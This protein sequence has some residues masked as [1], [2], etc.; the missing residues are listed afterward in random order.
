MHGASFLNR[1]HRKPFPAATPSWQLAPRPRIKHEKWTAGSALETWTVAAA[2]GVRFARVRWENNFLLIFETAPFFCKHPVYTDF[3][4]SYN[5]MWLPQAPLKQ[6]HLGTWR[7]VTTD[8]KAHIN[9][10]RF[11]NG[12]IRHAFYLINKHIKLCKEWY[13]PSTRDADGNK[14]PAARNSSNLIIR[15]GNLHTT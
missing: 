11:P 12:H 8:S 10:Q 4:I 13:S 15:A 1:A 2:D 14:S 7:Q 6:S 5:K 9:Q 3:K